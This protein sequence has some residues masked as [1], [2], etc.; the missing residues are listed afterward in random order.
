MRS[1]DEEVVAGEPEASPL[2]YRLPPRA[3]AHAEAVKERLD[4]IRDA[5]LPNETECPPFTQKQRQR[6][7]AL[8]SRDQLRKGP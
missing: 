1:S 6:L 4:R 3:K 7:R 5:A 2:A 8:A